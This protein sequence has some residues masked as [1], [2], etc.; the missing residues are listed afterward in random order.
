MGVTQALLHGRRSHACVT[1]M[2][3]PRDRSQ[4]AYRDQGGPLR[5]NPVIIT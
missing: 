2:A 3:G 1:V 5:R 4:L